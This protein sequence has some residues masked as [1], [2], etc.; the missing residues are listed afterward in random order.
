VDFRL[1]DWMWAFVA[2]LGLLSAAA[3]I[4]FVIHPGGFEGQ[5]GWFVA[6]MPGAI[7][8]LPLADRVFKLA[9]GAERVALW[10]S[11][12]GITF[13]W[14]FAISYAAIKTY[15]FVARASGS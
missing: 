15:R 12:V 8:G 5:I 1:A 6:L 7:F 3:F 13:L 2:A 9:P 10:S 14:Y 11:V 4:I